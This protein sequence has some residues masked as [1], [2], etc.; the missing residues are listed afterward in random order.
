MS[1]QQISPT[2]PQSRQPKGIPTGGQF[3][4][5]AHSEAGVALV[6]EGG[7]GGDTVDSIASNGEFV[8][9][10]A[11]WHATDEPDSLHM[12]EVADWGQRLLDACEKDRPGRGALEAATEAWADLDE[13]DIDAANDIAAAIE[14]VTA[15]SSMEVVEDGN[16]GHTRLFDLEPGHTCPDCGNGYATG[17]VLALHRDQDCT[18]FDQTRD[19]SEDRDYDGH[20]D[21][22][23]YDTLHSAAESFASGINNA[24]RATQVAFLRRM[25][26][27]D[28]DMLEAIEMAGPGQEDRALDDLVIDACSESASQAYNDGASDGAKVTEDLESNRWILGGDKPVV[29]KH[30]V[31]L[32]KGEST[33]VTFTVDG[34][35][36]TYRVCYDEWVPNGDS[37]TLAH[38]YLRGEFSAESEWAQNE[39]AHSEESSP[40]RPAKGE[41]QQMVGYAWDQFHTRLRAAAERTVRDRRADPLRPFI[42]GA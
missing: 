16:G 5:S 40:F 38:G 20:E 31:A 10:L 35:P 17:A 30:P 18:G 9:C 12:D 11:R 6:P 22:G 15:K 39:Y 7:G 26:V 1:A 25:R 27:S 19:Y 34:R 13:H 32:A 21:D 33:M 23:R 24:G 3:A 28:D 29:A 4:A 37:G 41:K 14:L 42:D 36:V 8:D 2:S